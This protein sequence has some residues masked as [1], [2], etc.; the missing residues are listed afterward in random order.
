MTE[1]L[2][3]LLLSRW[4][5]V[6]D[7]LHETALKL[8]AAELAFRP[9]TGAYTAGETLLH[10]AH[11]ELI[12]VHY[13]IT[14]ALDGVPPAY[15]ASEFPDVASILATLDEVHA[16]TV[17]HLRGLTDE[18]LLSDIQAPWGA[19]QQQVAA[20]M[21]V[22]EHEIHHRGELSLM[23]GLLGKTDLDA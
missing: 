19:R 17:E 12:E 8:D 20:L 1:A 13:G 15:D 11:E 6:R 21:H 23:L 4:Q 7:G 16:P 5:L 22:I 9:A 2:R 10:V 3:D 14:G 18:A